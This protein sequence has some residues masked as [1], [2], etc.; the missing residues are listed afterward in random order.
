[1][2]V[3]G[4]RER[5]ERL[6]ASTQKMRPDEHFAAVVEGY[7]HYGTHLFNAILHQEAITPVDTDV[8]HTNMPY[9]A[10]TGPALARVREATAALRVIEDMRILYVRGNVEVGDDAIAELIDATRTMQRV[11]ASYFPAGG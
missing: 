1:V 11:A 7:T 2:D 9:I 6:W 8:V 4:H 3:K 10:V 5:A